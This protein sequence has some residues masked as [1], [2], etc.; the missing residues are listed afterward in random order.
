MGIICWHPDH[1][2]NTIGAKKA[3]VIPGA[4]QQANVAKKMATAFGIGSEPFALVITDPR[5]LYAHGP[6]SSPLRKSV[7]ESRRPGWLEPR[8]SET[9]FGVGQSWGPGEGRA[10]G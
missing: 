8:T 10:A 9:G 6:F 7:L 5:A 2:L 3:D 4:D 1:E